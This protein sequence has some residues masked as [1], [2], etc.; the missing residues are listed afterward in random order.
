MMKILWNLQLCL[1]DSGNDCHRALA[2]GSKSSESMLHVQ[3]PLS[4]YTIKL[5]LQRANI[6]GDQVCSFSLN[7]ITG[8]HDNHNMHTH[9]SYFQIWFLIIIK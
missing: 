2:V 9:F 4:S 7:Q 1:M 3:P 5:L 6:P 8:Y